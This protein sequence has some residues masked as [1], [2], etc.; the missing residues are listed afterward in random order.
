MKI[1]KHIIFL[2][3]MLCVCLSFSCSR[4]PMLD[5]LERIKGVG[6]KNP[7]MA[8][9][10]L[11]SLE[12]EIRG[13]NEY[14][15]NKYDLL[16]IRLNDKAEHMPNSD[17]MIKNLIAYF[18]NNGSNEDKQEVFYY[19]GSVYRDLHD[20][21]RALTNFLKSIDYANRGKCDS[22]ML[23]NTYS[24]INYL[25][26]LVQNY[27]EAV[28]MAKKEYEM[29]KSLGTDEVL[30]NLH[31]GSSYLALHRTKQA[32]AAFDAA[33]ALIVRAK[34]ISKYQ[35]LLIDMLE[36]YS[37]MKDIAKAKKCMSLIDKSALADSS[38]ASCM[39]FAQYYD[40]MG[41]HDSA[42]IYCKRI[43]DNVKDITYIYDASRLLF[44][45]YEKNGNAGDACKY[46]DITMRMSDS[47]DFGKRQEMAATVNNEFQYHL[48]EK[49]EHAL[50]C[51][52][53][54]YRNLLVGGSFFM[55]LMVCI[56]Y[57]LY[58]KKKNKDLQNILAL[59][60]ELQRVSEDD[61]K[62][63]EEIEQKEIE[64]RNSKEGL[65]KNSIELDKAKEELQC[66]N[67]EL[68]IYSK[69]LNEKEQELSDKKKQNK[70][71]TRLLHLS[72]LEDNAEEIVRAI[73]KS[74]E[75]KRSL[76]T[77]DWKLLY[78]AVDKLY[79]SFKDSLFKELG[80]CNEQQ[81]QV[82]YLI[83][84]GVSRNLI[85]LLTGLSRATVWRWSKKY[86]RVMNYE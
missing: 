46:A 26:Y 62:L 58:V 57:V 33:L 68:V 79:P 53:N 73:K 83:H 30:P 17:I 27:K 74:A 75:D 66:V 36:D 9:S 6:D 8:L 23:R 61:R 32:K 38:A 44:R 80:S 86:D 1:K 39:A 50:N 19:A 15:K 28:K 25:Q 41:N 67:E 2:L 43:V 47:I 24:D 59:S 7:D 31:I 56:A 85:P 49:K 69:R 72:K 40:A 11:D 29:C 13:E 22:I 37:D 3:C 71:I 55:I 10:M 76:E 63:H 48:D 81:M 42:I 78:K 21:P 84:I 18:K 35:S 82:C 52:I 45:I 14:V 54:R 60:S 5:E 77:A 51:K 65:D 4:N 70:E 20:T 16:R 12:L 34:N 64:L